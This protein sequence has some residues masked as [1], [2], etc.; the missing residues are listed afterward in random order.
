[1]KSNVRNAYL[2]PYALWIILFVVAPILLILYYSF[3]D[4][5]GKWTFENYEK[6]LTPIYLKMTLNSFWY[7]FLITLFSLLVAYPTAYLLTK[8]KHKQLWLLLIIL[9]TWVNLLLKV[10]AFLGIF[11]TFGLAN[12]ILKT[13]GIGAKQ[14]LF[15]DFS[16]IFVSVYI[17]IPFMVLPIF[18][19]L[20][21]LNPSLIDAARD[22]GA[23]AW[24]TFRRVVF[25]LTLSGVKAGCQAVFIPSLSLFM[26]TRLIAGNRVIT[27]GTAIEEH[28]LV[29]QDWGMGATIAVFL[30]LA[31]AVI[32][33]MT[34]S[35]KRGK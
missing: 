4:I 13:I 33:G 12:A 14:I 27:L 34:G 20:E 6:F 17:F 31:M 22:L 32:V 21:E 1:M 24:T 18:N 30:M 15:T 5:E 8:T 26:I 25:P 2:I 28:F 29:T 9:P 10:Y 19:A 35:R 23:S 11:G 3:F 7:A 16:F